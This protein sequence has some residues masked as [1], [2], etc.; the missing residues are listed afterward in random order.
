MLP[1]ESENPNGLHA[2]YIVTKASG[3]PCDPE[4]VYFVLRLD[5]GGDDPIHIQGAEAVTDLS[6]KRIE[7][8]REMATE[9]LSDIDQL[10]AAT[11]SP[12]DEPISR[13]WFE[14]LPGWVI[15]YRDEAWFAWHGDVEVFPN[16][17]VY[18]SDCLI[19][20]RYTTRESVLELCRVIGIDAIKERA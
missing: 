18:I 19:P 14:S 12:P 1:T 16:G 15:N 17:E 20:R 3:E 10:K 5:R 6:L 2:R 11:T 9:I 8:I 7:A 4:A 13:E